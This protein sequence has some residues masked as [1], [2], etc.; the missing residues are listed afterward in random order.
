MATQP[1]EITRL[2]D[3]ARNH[4][5]GALDATIKLELFNVLDEIL[6]ASN[7]W[8][9]EIEVSTRPG[10]TTYDLAGAEDGAIV[11]LLGCVNAAGT[12]VTAA[13]PTPGALELAREPTTAEV[14]TVTVAY[15]VVD[16]A[17]SDDYPR[18]PDGLIQKYHIGILAG[19]VG[20]MMAQPAKPYTNERMAIFNIRKFT[21]AVAECRSAVK[22]GNIHGGQTWRFPRFAPGRQRRG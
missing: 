10:K 5:P 1:A 21:G 15:T 11:S 17:G 16:P 4:V 2:M 13:M 9:E 8:Q 6:Q 12:P 7:F 3:N 18:V 14:L 22:H 20:R 19:V